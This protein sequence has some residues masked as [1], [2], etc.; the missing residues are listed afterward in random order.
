[1]IWGII[2]WQI[3]SVIFIIAK[4]YNKT[5]G[6]MSKGM[7][8]CGMIFECINEFLLC[9]NVKIND[10][11]NKQWLVIHCIGAKYATFTLFMCDNAHQWE[12][13][14][15][16]LSVSNAFVRR[17]TCRAY[18]PTWFCSRIVRMVYPTSA[19]G[20]KTVILDPFKFFFPIRFLK[21]HQCFFKCVSSV[22][23]VL[24]DLTQF[25]YV[26]VQTKDKLEESK[27]FFQYS[28]FYKSK[29]FLSKNIFIMLHCF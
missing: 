21:H 11:M 18:W 23:L 10:T 26:E 1:M 28:K 14:S 5:M 15:V 29:F 24:N 20:P 6:R 8:E 3:R 4:S 2:K 7:N 16:G 25:A 17:S 22:L 13:L 27:H 9:I 19:L 12:V